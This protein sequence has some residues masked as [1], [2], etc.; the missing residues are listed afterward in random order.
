MY[1]NSFDKKIDNCQNVFSSLNNSRNDDSREVRVNRGGYDSIS[2]DKKIND[3]FNS[4][5][6]IYKADVKILTDKGLINKRIVAR[7]K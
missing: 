7:K 3:I 4:S 1:K 6:Y 5:N 2:I